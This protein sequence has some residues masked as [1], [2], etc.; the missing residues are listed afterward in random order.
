MA[1]SARAGGGTLGVG[2]GG[3]EGDGELDGETDALGEG[4]ALGLVRVAV[5]WP[6]PPVSMKAANTTSPRRS[7]ASAPISDFSIRV[8]SE[9]GAWLAFQRGMPPITPL[10]ALSVKWRAGRG[11]LAPAACVR[12]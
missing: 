1:A 5:A 6:E 4:D 8:M 2:A 10:R 3:G 12:E 7:T 9:R 11:G